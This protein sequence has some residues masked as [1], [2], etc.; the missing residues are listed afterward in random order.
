MTWRSTYILDNFTH[1]NMNGTSNSSGI[2][3]IHRCSHC[4]DFPGPDP[5][6]FRESN[7]GPAQNC[8]ANV[9]IHYNLDPTFFSIPAVPR[10]AYSWFHKGVPYLASPH[11][12]DLVWPKEGHCPMLPE[13][14]IALLSIALVYY[15]ICMFTH[16]CNDCWWRLIK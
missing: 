11:I 12:A 14:V 4:K 2:S 3:G 10:V 5:K 1:K 6:N 9:L 15:N 16:C 13:Y 7:M 8:A